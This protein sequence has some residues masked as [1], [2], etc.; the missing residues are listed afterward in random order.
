MTAHKIYGAALFLVAALLFAS[1]FS[2]QYADEPL[3][4]DVSTVFL[5]RAYLIV[6]MFFAALVFVMGTLGHYKLD[7]PAVEWGRLAAI[8]LTGIVVAWAMLTVGFLIATIPGIWVF[9][10]IF[11][12]RKPVQLTI[13]S[14]AMPLSVWFLFI[15]V[16]ELL[17]PSSPWFN[18]F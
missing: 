15:Y 17:L 5:P 2:A 14:V 8:C 16:F 4:G 7:F 1:T 10:W 11:G 13:F 6:W 18:S 9:T 3:G 12:Y